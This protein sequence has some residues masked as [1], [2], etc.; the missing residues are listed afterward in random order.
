MGVN[1]FV[2]GATGD[3]FKRK[4]YP[5]IK[6]LKRE[7]KIFA[8]GRKDLSTKDF[9][10]KYIEK[11]EKYLEYIKI[12]YSKEEDYKKIFSLL[13][14]K[15]IFY[16]A[17]PPKIFKEF[18]EKIKNFDLKNIKVAFEKPFGVDK[19]SFEELERLL[20][21]NFKEEQ[22]YLVDHYLGK[23]GVIKIAEFRRRKEYEKYW[24][25][26]FIKKIKIVAKEEIGIEG[27][28]EY[29][30]EMGAIKDM[31]QNHLFQIL[32]FATSNLSKENK[33]EL[34][35]SIKIKNIFLGQYEEYQKEIEKKSDTETFAR[36][37]LK[38][39]TLEWKETE[40]EIITGKKLD[41]KETKVVVEFLEKENLPKEII[42]EIYPKE[43][44]CTKDQNY[45]CNFEEEKI[46][47][48]YVNILE[49]I[50]FGKKDIFPDIEE[51]H[52]SWEIIDKI[53]KQN[54]TIYKEGTNEE[55]II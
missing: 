48:A 21:L 52:A 42:F 38:I 45:S 51:L 37:N 17:T 41:K 10:E 11:G 32:L 47:N 7:I 36:L 6:E 15:N 50:I 43:R 20:R 16:L 22:I 12:D 23:Q 31:I 18:L 28:R 30:E 54:L 1:L 40:I 35:K 55:E 24:N 8:V 26:N 49:K 19:E 3:L 25:S 44:I 39:E 5:A 27:R 2:F 34:L 13:G 4:I 14:E 33:K 46:K 9:L 29:Y 53:G